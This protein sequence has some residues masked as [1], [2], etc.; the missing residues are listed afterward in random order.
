MH[1]SHAGCRCDDAPIEENGK[2]YC[3]ELCAESA[4]KP[5]GGAC[6]CGHPDCAAV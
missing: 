5:A 4:Q 3:S 1:C 6:P 2:R